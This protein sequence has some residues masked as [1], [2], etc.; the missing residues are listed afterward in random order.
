MD[1]S[2]KSYNDCK[3]DNWGDLWGFTR[4]PGPTTF[5]T[6]V[7][8]FQGDG[9]FGPIVVQRRLYTGNAAEFIRDN[10]SDSRYAVVLGFYNGQDD[11]GRNFVYLAK[12][13]S[14]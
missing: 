4:A 13:L 2:N 11:P 9:R 8:C 10:L 5:D 12:K 1:V 3:P 14:Q 7:V 6:L